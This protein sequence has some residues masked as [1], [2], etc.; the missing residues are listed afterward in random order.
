VLNLARA[1]HVRR[2]T[3]DREHVSLAPDEAHPVLTARARSEGGEERLEESILI[4]DSDAGMDDQ[5]HAR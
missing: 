2:P 5:R 4:D 1:A 3:L